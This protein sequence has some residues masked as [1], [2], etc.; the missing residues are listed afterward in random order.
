MSSQHPEVAD[1]FRAHADDYFKRYGT[2]TSPQQKRVLTD[3]MACRTAALGGHLRQC[4]LC[5]HDEVYYNSCRNRHCPKCQ[6]AARAKWLRARAAD[7][8]PVQY[9][10]VV[11][12]IADKLR[13]VTL[14]NKRVIYN[15]LF[16]AV[17]ET[18]C[19]LG[20][21]PKHLGAHIGFIAL[22]HTWGQTMQLHPHIHCVVPGGGLS[23][24]GKCWISCREDFLL[25]VR[26]MSSLYQKKFLAYLKA[27]Y[28]KGDLSFH[29]SIAYLRKKKDWKHFLSS[30]YRT[31]CNVYSKQPFGGP[32]QVLKYLA[33]YTHRVAIANQRLIS[34]QNGR[35]SFWWKDYSDESRKKIMTLDAV[36]FI[37]RFLLH[38]LPDRFVRI[39]HYG[40]LSNRSRKEKLPLCREL[41]GTT[42]AETV[43]DAMPPE[44]GEGG[45]LV[46][47][48]D[49][50]LCPACKKGRMIRIQTIGP[51]RTGR[52]SRAP[53]SQSYDAT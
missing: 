10:H 37:R 33:R 41:L 38:V 30:L 19:V 32:E 25:S 46:E 3:L 52:S 14:Q 26:V 8:L 1:V 13:C 34:L 15:I 51:L 17:S 11:F 7:L 36:E 21:D 6:G 44:T 45:E 27:A 9:F 4:D 18:L 42:D 29:G 50:P 53:P 5:G 31:S 12:T 22:L 2:A 47:D 23:L 35:V 40:F 24:D 43:A 49:S 16:R 39:R 48:N 20:K 28:E